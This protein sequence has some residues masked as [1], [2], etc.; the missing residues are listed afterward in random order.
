MTFLDLS[1]TSLL[2]FILTSMVIELTPG[3]N[4]G[5]LAVLSATSGRLAGYAA[6]SGGR[7]LSLALAMIAL[8]FAWSTRT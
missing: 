7:V 4:M 8:W 6:V 2:S 1:L 3:P 5:Y